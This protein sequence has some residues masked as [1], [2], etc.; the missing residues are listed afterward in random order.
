MDII[1]KTTQYKSLANISAMSSEELI[2][3]SKNICINYSF[4]MSPFGKLLI[5]STIK[6]ICS[7]YMANDKQKAIESLIKKFP[8]A[9]IAKKQESTHLN[10]LSVFDRKLKTTE[11]IELHLKGTEFQIKVWKALLEIPIGE[12]STYGKISKAIGKPKACRA[13]GSAV[14]DNPIFFL[15]P[16]HRVV[17][18]TGAIGQY[19][20]GTEVKRSILQWEN[21]VHFNKSDKDSGK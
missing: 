17:L 19:Y 21:S 1:S 11:P 20:W 7:V 16:C 6:G 18:S 15:I 8:K 12:T 14:G 13:V 2:N 10:I 5:A 9:I 4:G 3:G